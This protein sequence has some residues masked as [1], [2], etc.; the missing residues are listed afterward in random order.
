MSTRTGKGRQVRSRI[1][2]IRYILLF[3]IFTFAWT[4]K[5][6]AYSQ[7][8]GS[9]WQKQVRDYCERKDWDSALRLINEEIGRAPQDMD[10]RAWHARVLTWSGRLE[11]AE[12]EY[13]EIF[14]HQPND[15]DI[16]QGL[17]TV[18]QR[19]GR[20]QQR[21]EALRRAVE[22]APGRTEL[23]I[24]FGR[25][26]LAAGDAAQ[27]RNEFEKALRQDP[28]SEEA[29][30]G[31]QSLRSE[32]KHE[33]RLG[34]EN[35][36][37]SFADSYHDEWVSLVSAWT[38]HWSTS[39]AGSSYQR[40]GLN[41]GKFLGSVTG[42]MP[43]WGALTV[44]GG[45]GHDNTV[46]PKHEVF[47]DLDHGWKTSEGGLLRGVELDYGQH[48]YWFQ[49]AHILS[50]NATSIVYM[51]QEWSFALRFTEARSSFAGTGT[52][53]RPS[54]MAR[55]GFPLKNQGS[56]RLS[57]N[58]FYAAGTEDFAEVDQIG[59]FASQTYGGG[60]RFQFTSRQDISGYASY[61]KR[62]QNRTDLGFG[63]SYGI[64]F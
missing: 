14:R 32:P 27:A 25:A 3:G 58:V 6:C 50:L 29:R 53:W 52:E 21:L 63:F 46:I 33:L 54:G 57:G 56:R 4:V 24:A 49:T 20:T 38:T 47:F 34:Q 2:H 31:M 28:A 30:A 19:E 48:W 7:E 8:Q 11:E 51:P 61:Q 17:A 26:L 44:G 62:T 16:W 9:G 10:V 5:L 22:I 18:Y 15:A 13:A 37:L 42:R 64:H 23:H 12:K 60:L 39:F 41:A 45:A 55:L 35:D 40:A 36:L 43:K 59:R 1:L